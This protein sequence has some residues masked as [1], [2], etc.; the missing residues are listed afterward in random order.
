MNIAPYIV[1][2]KAKIF[3]ASIKVNIFFIKKDLKLY[4]TKLSVMSSQ[5][6]LASQQ[7]L[8]LV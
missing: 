1:R 5:S 2:P 8:S 4:I 6:L 7:V 3:T